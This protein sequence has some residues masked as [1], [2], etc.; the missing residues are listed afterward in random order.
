[1]MKQNRILSALSLLLV[2]LAI[3]CKPSTR[4]Q[5][6]EPAEIKIDDHINKI[7]TID[8]SKPAKGF[9]NV[10]EGLLTGEGINQDKQGRI[11]ALEGLSNMMTR[12][13]RFEVI[14]S[15]VQLTG[16]KTGE[17]KIDPLDWDEIE[18]ICKQYGTDALIAL[19]SYD[20]DNFVDVTERRETYK[21]GDGNEQER[22]YFESLNRIIVKIGWRFYDPAKK[23]II[24]DYDT[25]DEVENTASGD[26]KGDAES[27]LPN[28]RDVARNVSGIAG[29][30]Y[31]RRIAPVWAT[32]ERSYFHKAKGANE[33]EMSEAA[34]FA[35]MGKWREAADIW[36]GITNTTTDKK[37][38][39][40]AAYNMAVASE[41]LGKL[42]IALEWA[43]KSYLNF[44]Q[45]KGK[46]YASTLK[47]R[48][49]DR[50]K[51]EDQLPQ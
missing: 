44:G 33:S 16:S 11:V 47:R 14:H 31:G 36:R 22:V 18:R 23:V 40:K 8:R 3:G 39:G 6:L 32:I 41:V 15:G 42:E 46:E 43:E 35:E 4:L 1:M 25:F 51:A 34:R 50:N 2:F 28:Q 48:I 27:S 5:V 12:T 19:E 20:S 17:R 10:L 29:E 9:I 38:G 26:T 7:V 30:L 24:D 45:S 21:D 37:T 49:Y 13:P